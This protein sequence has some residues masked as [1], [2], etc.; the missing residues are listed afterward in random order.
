MQAIFISYRREDA[1]GHAGRL[2]DDLC[3]RL[4]KKSVFMDVAGIQPGRD[5]R[6]VIHEQVGECGVL[7][8]VIGPR[9]LD[10]RDSGGR[11]RLDNPADYVRLETATAL[12]RDIPVVPVLVNGA[13]MMQPEDLPPEL[14]DLAYRNAFEV[15]DTRW[16]PDIELLAVTLRAILDGRSANDTMTLRPLAAMPPVVSAAPP[17]PALATAPAIPTPAPPPAKRSPALWA[18]AGLA[19]A[20]AAGAA[21]VA[22]RPPTPVQP[23]PPDR[24]AAAAV[25]ASAPAAPAPAAGPA[26][27]PVQPQAASAPVAVAAAS[28]PTAEVAASATLAPASAV[29]VATALASAPAPA[30]ASAPAPLVAAAPAV[31][32]LA[33]PAEPTAAGPAASAAAPPPKPSPTAPTAATQRPREPAKVNTAA[34]GN[35][36]STLTVTG[37]KV[38]LGGCGGPPVAVKGVATFSIEPAGRGVRVTQLLR[39]QD[40]GWNATITGEAQF[41]APRPGRYELTNH[42]EWTHVQGRRFRTEAR[43]VVISPDGLKAASARGIAIRT[44]CA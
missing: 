10:A 40:Q 26:S 35:A 1:S 11:R 21:F 20:G 42:G 19:L 34:S 28:V 3:E 16:R 36:G 6:K 18:G 31:P 39:I 44:L 9:W 7:L 23:A 27:T 4:G 32:P 25:V 38:N 13:Q 8:A 17:A 15:R 12:Q 5:F 37:W 41:D 14:A 29:A 24:L 2:F 33:L 30:A 43:V 22:L